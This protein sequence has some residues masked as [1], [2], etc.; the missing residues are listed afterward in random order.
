MM[1]SMGTGRGAGRKS[2]SPST[3]KLEL[4]ESFDDGPV[5]VLQSDAQ[6]ILNI[7]IVVP[8][9]MFSFTGRVGLG[10]RNSPHQF[11]GAA[12]LKPGFSVCP[13]ALYCSFMFR[14]WSSKA[15]NFGVGR[16]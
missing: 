3:T 12:L 6:T 14:M 9:P 16:R 15:L 1:R 7:V 11:Q 5:G 8:R 4:L 10:H 2:C 13:G